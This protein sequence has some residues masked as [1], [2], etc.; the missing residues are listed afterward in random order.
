MSGR[1][2]DTFLTQELA[3]YLLCS[4]FLTGVLMLLTLPV[5]TR[6]GVSL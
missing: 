1:I 5:A 6:A 4:F 2:K 3:L